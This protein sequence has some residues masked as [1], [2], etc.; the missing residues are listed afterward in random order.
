MGI[1]GCLRGTLAGVNQPSSC[2]LVVRVRRGA[3]EWPLGGPVERTHEEMRLG[4]RL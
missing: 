3:S 4:S 1:S 2:A